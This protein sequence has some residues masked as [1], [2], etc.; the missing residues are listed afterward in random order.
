MIAGP[1]TAPQIIDRGLTNIVGARFAPGAASRWLGV[2]VSELVNLR[3]DLEALWGSRAAMLVDRLAAS[4]TIGETS[5]RLQK[6]LADLAGT[7]APP[8][9]A[10]AAAYRRFSHANGIVPINDLAA[11]LNVSERTLRRQFLDHFGY[12]PK[13]LERILRFQKFLRL[14]RQDP[15]TGIG[16]LAIDAHYADQAHLSREARCLSGLSPA[17]LLQH[18]A[19]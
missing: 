6:G 14:G 11:M 13:T 12:G 7:V 19:A 2:P 16:A 4:A 5:A 1:D 17:A 8:D 9:R 18:L 10:M 15:E 3:V